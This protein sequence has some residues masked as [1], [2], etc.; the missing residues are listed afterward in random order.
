MQQASGKV[1]DVGNFA[2]DTAAPKVAVDSKCA[3][4]G[5]FRPEE[6]KCGVDAAFD[7]ST[8]Q[9]D[10]QPN[11]VVSFAPPQAGK[12]VDVDRFERRK[13]YCRELC[14]VLLRYASEAETRDLALQL[15]DVVADQLASRYRPGLNAAAYDVFA[16]Y[17]LKGGA[18]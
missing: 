6:P 3:V 13:Q 2:K 17:G 4:D 12:S 1:A 5:T 10:P 14:R 9:P 8:P 18:Q 15:E 11:N 7:G 16:R